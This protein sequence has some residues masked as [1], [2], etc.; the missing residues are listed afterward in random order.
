[1]EMEE[2]PMRK[3]RIVNTVI[4]SLAVLTA[5][6]LAIPFALVLGAPFLGGF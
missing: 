5:L 6:A 4:D 1:M 3:M 2:A